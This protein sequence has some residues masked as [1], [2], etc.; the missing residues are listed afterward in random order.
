M[1]WGNISD[2]VNKIWDILEDHREVIEGLAAT[3]ESIN[4]LRTN[5]VMKVLTVI[6]TIMLPMAVISGIYGMNIDV[7]PFAHS[8]YSFVITVGAMLLTLCSFLTYFRL[9]RLI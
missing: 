7:L 2:H 4:T 6:S 1:Y 9:R 8:P 5:E 3:S